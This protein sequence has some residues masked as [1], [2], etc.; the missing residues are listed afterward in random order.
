MSYNT[1][2]DIDLIELYWEIKNY[3]SRERDGFN[4]EPSLETFS[5][6]DKVLSTPKAREFIDQKNRQ[7]INEIAN[8]ITKYADD[9]SAMSKEQ[10]SRFISEY[11]CY[12][13]QTSLVDELNRLKKELALHSSYIADPSRYAAMCEKVGSKDRF[14]ELYLG[15]CQGVSLSIK[16]LE[17]RIK[18]QN[19]PTDIG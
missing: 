13:G 6:L 19:P 5:E 16:I 14:D 2:D 17:D 18:D 1:I 7:R 15:Y 10:Q 9:F 12:A 3:L 11:Q 8:I 4:W